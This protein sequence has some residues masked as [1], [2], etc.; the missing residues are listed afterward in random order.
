MVAT[1]LRKIIVFYRAKRYGL[2]ANTHFV[3][4]KVKSSILLEMIAP[5]M[6]LKTERSYSLVNGIRVDGE[7]VIR[8]EDPLPIPTLFL[9]TVDAGKV[10]ADDDDDGN[11]AQKACSD[12]SYSSNGGKESRSGQNAHKRKIRLE[13][14]LPIPPLF[15][16]AADESGATA[17]DDDDGNS[18]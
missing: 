10:V 4:T 12:S 14:P 11:S 1:S 6:P 15:L 3:V 17:N 7:R 13:D 8:L 9:N 2:P 16:N 5:K 18:T